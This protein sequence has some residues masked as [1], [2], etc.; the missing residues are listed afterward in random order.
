VHRS[1]LRHQQK[2]IAPLVQYEYLRK[3]IEV[4]PR[5]RDGAVLHEIRAFFL[6]ALSR[7]EE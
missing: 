4:S 3:Q 7:G 6:S 2:G 1:L 5:I